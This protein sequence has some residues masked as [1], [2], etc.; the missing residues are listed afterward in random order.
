M[1]EVKRSRRYYLHKRLE[2]RLYSFDDSEAFWRAK[3]EAEP[4]TPLAATL[5]HRSALAD[6]GYSTVEDLD[7]ADEAELVRAGLNQSQAKAIINAL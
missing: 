1:A 2:A 6:V 3:Q 5:P 7:G 4:G